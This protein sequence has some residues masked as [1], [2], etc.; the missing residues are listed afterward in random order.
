VQWDTPAGLSVNA[1]RTAIGF[2]GRWCPAP[3]CRVYKSHR[4]T[5]Q[6]PVRL[7]VC[8]QHC[9]LR[10]ADR[11]AAALLCP[12]SGCPVDRRR[13]QPLTVE[14]PVQVELTAEPSSEKISRWAPLEVE[15]AVY[16][17]RSSVRPVAFPTKLRSGRR[18]VCVSSIAA[19]A[20]VPRRHAA[21]AVQRAHPHENAMPPA[22]V[23]CHRHRAPLRMPAWACGHPVLPGRHAVQAHMAVGRTPDASG[24]PCPVP[25]GPRAARPSSL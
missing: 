9:P 25:A 11:S 4:P 20:A 24:P 21:G 19:L 8:F 5:A 1:R 7:C 18:R 12:R 17:D 16:L 22:A 3:F 15:L 2:L 14:L 23:L 13:S 6:P 10:R